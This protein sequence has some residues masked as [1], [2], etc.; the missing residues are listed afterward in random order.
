M[1][2]DN[3]AKY[4]KNSK[5]EKPPVEYFYTVKAI[6]NV[7]LNQIGKVNSVID[8]GCNKGTWLFVMQELGIDK[9]LGIDGTWVP[10]DKLFIKE[11]NFIAKN[12]EE[13]LVLNRTFDLV[14]CLEVAEHLSKERAGSFIHDLTKLGDLVLF[15]AAIPNQGGR[16]HINEQF[17]SYWITRFKEN[18]Y[19]VIDIRDSIKKYCIKQW[20][21]AQNTLLFVKKSALTKYPFLEHRVNEIPIYNYIHNAILKHYE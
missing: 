2:K 15:G 10:K 12:L 8:V 20:W 5:Y 18:N 11:D 16:H 6:V 3:I 17:P 13:P 1:N 9:V 19:C 21:Y 14:L 7:I 4:Y